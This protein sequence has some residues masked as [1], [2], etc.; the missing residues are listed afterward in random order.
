MPTAE[1]L[2]KWEDYVDSTGKKLGVTRQATASMAWLVSAKNGKTYA[3]KF[4]NNFA[5]KHLYTSTKKK[6]K[7]EAEA[8]RLFKAAGSPQGKSKA[9]YMVE[10][11]K[12][13]T[14]KKFSKQLGHRSTEEQKICGVCKHEWGLH[15]TKTGNAK[16]SGK[17]CDSPGCTCTGWTLLEAYKKK[18]TT[19][20]KPEVNPLAGATTVKNTVI[21]MNKIPKATFEAV[22]SDSII[23]KETALGTKPWGDGH[24]GK[25]A[26]CE[27]IEWD[28]KITGSVVKLEGDDP[29]K[30]TQLDKVIVTI[31]TLK[32]TDAKKPGYMVVHMN[33]F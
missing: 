18:R 16:L 33:P 15:F 27:H 26:D 2:L 1:E 23:A 8:E 28:F 14:E 24:T 13:L 11:E 19:Q 10:A 5:K 22:V 12:N 31:K 4:D 7:I 32:S 17:K 9:D 25:E 20:G 3:I 6:D 21:W 30:W 29:S